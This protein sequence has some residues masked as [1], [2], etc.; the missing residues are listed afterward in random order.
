MGEAQSCGF[1][2]GL[3]LVK[4]KKTKERFKAEDAVGMR[5]RAHCFTH[6]LVM[7]AVGDRMIIAPP[8]VMTRTDIDQMMRLI[9]LA[10]DKT[11]QELKSLNFM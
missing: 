10:L 7:R 4:N 3:L 2:A 8:L 6:G 5:C 1:V 11:G 9:R